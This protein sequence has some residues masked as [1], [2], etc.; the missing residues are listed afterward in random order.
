MNQQEPGAFTGFGTQLRH[1]LELMDADVAGVLDDLGLTDYRPRFSPV[2]R[3]LV[4]LGPLPIRELARAVS[5]THSA[6]SQTVA[7]MSKRDFV[8][9]EPG[10]DARQ[11]VVHL[12]ERT[13]KALPLIQAEWAATNSAA[14]ELDAEL[15]FPLGEL[16]PAIAAALERKPFRQRIV[17]SAWSAAH[18]SFGA[19]IKK[20]AIEKKE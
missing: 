2:V 3:A 17:E 12:T 15:P 1:A 5:V 6:A 19:A 13:R 10:K 18:P 11:R 20:D 16:V 9:L 14:E 4:A 7:E 8:V